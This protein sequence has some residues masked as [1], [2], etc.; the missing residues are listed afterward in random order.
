VPAVRV[1]CGDRLPDTQCWTDQLELQ[2]AI[3]E[4]FESDEEKRLR[5]KEDR[6]PVDQL[7]EGFLRLMVL[8]DDLLTKAP[9][10]VPDVDRIQLHFERELPSLESLP[11]AP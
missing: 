6:Y 5:E 10:L 11:T 4:Q 3:S 9:Q 1:T 2:A 8:L 7:D